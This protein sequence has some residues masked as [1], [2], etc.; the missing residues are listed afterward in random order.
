MLVDRIGC[1][2]DPKKYITMPVH[3]T[4]ATLLLIL[5][6]T[7]MS[8]S[9]QADELKEIAQQV[10]Q[11]KQAAALDRLNTYLK[12]H[13]SDA[14][15][16]FLKGV[17]LSEL[18]KRDEAIRIFTELTEKHPELPEPYNNLA[19][20]YASQGQYDKARKALEAALKTHPSYATAHNNLAD[21]YAHMASEAYDKALQLDKGNTRTNA[22]KLAMIDDLPTAATPTMIAARA[23]EVAKTPTRIAAVAKPETPPARPIAKTE[24]PAPPPAVTPIK[25]SE[26][27]KPAE[28]A[29]PAAAEKPAAAGKPAKAEP[30]EP[31]K[32]TPVVKP[33]EPPAGK[34]AAPAA[35][36]EKNI[37]DAVNGWALAW[38][39]QNVEKYL[40]SYAVSFKTPNGESRKQWEA[41]R[42]ERLTRPG[43][44]KVDISN[45]RVIMDSSD[46]ARAVFKQ[47]YRAGSTVMRTS[48]TLVF[49]NAGGKWLIEQERTGS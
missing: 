1:S 18:N 5:S 3:R 33:A 30:S 4:L 8:G 35:D 32:P 6:G 26:P 24:P 28:P 44:I 48:K 7:L 45:L 16:M 25:L 37:R 22:S 43:A 10:Q 17:A 20:L 39:S 14:Q 46:Q 41:T 42:R 12:A 47:T 49:R 40:A 19:V 13:P 23:P 11:G 9:L 38:S 34:P 31:A 15:A 21:V 36:S 29:P 27:T 2:N